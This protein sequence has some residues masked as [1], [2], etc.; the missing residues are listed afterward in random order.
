MHGG[1]SD[2][3]LV[4]Y[5]GSGT[6]DRRF[7]H[8]DERG[9]V[10]AVSDATGAVTN[11][12]TYDEYGLPAPTNIGR[13]QYTGQKWI[14]E[15][16]LYDYK[17]RMYHPQL[18]RF[19][20]T[21]PIGDGMNHYAYVGGDPV[22]FTDPLGLA[23]CYGSRIRSDACTGSESDSPYPTRQLPMVPG[24]SGTGPGRTVYTLLC[25]SHCGQERH[26]E[27]G[28]PVVH[29]PQYEWVSNTTRWYVQNGR[30]L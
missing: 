22:N 16:G 14:A 1:G 15:L 2:E 12:N 10:V 4:W 9:S 5:E 25:R 11:V 28:M 19:V 26:E 27:D 8:A 6:G 20:Q 13:F 7:L 21:D 18:G 23:K 17:A 29:A 24:A 30:Y 3:P